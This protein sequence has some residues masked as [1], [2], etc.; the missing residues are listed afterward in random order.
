MSQLRAEALGETLA[1]PALPQ[2]LAY[3]RVPERL[4]RFGTRAED[5]RID[6]R[7]PRAPLTTALLEVCGCDSAGQP[8]GFAFAAELELGKRVECLLVLAMADR[9]QRELTLVCPFED[10]GKQMELE[11]DLAELC[12][13]QAEA[14]VVAEIALPDSPA[15]RRPTAQDLALWLSGRY[16]DEAEAREALVRQLVLAAELRERAEPILARW[17]KLAEALAEADPLLDFAIHTHCPYCERASRHPFDLEGFALDELEALRGRLIGDIHL[18]ASHYHWG[19]DAIL[20]LP[21]WRRQA[22]LALILAERKP[23]EDSLS[24]WPR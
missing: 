22:Y 3:V 7:L 21:E 1:F 14:E 24:G 9:P 2:R 18:L 5:L 13:L 19:E 4:R 23:N 6:F 15:L 17:P 8:S 16:A 20:A 11:L 10:C 12:A